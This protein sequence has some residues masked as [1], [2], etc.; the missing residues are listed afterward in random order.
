MPKNMGRNSMNWRTVFLV[1]CGS[2]LGTVST[3]VY[4]NGFDV[5]V[6]IAVGVASFL[7]AVSLGYAS[8]LGKRSYQGIKSTS[9]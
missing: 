5:K 7:G 9:R 2:T 3:Y 1:S 8:T 4:F 6:L